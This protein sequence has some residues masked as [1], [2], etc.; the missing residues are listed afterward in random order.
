MAAAGHNEG[1]FLRVGQGEIHFERRM[2]PGKI[3]LSFSVGF[4]F[5][6]RSTVKSALVSLNEGGFH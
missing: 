5:F 3:D 4:L 6:V 1:R 2:V